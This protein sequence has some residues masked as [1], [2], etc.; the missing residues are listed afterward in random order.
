MRLQALISNLNCKVL[1]AAD[2]DVTGICYDSRKVDKGSPGSGVIFAAMPGEHVDGRAFVKDAVARGASCVLTGAP[3]SG[4]AAPQVVVEDVREALS[5]IS[6]AFY[7]DPSS[8]LKIAGVTGTNGKTTTAYLLES[9]FKEAGFQ[10]G[11]IGTVNYRYGG[12]IREAPHTTPQ[13]PELQKILKEMADSGVTHCA[14]EVSSHAL[15]QK[16]VLGCGFDTAVFTNLTHEHLDYHRT[17]DEYFRCKSLLFKEL[18]KERSGPPAVNIDDPWGARLARGLKEAL[19]FSLKKGASIYPEKYD[20]K[21]GG[22]EASVKTPRGA[23]SISSNLAGEYN[24]HN[25]LGAVGA[26][27]SLGI[28]ID[29]ISSGVAA[30]KRVPGRLEKIESTAPGKRFRAYVDYAHTGDALERALGALRRISTGRIIT[31]FGCGGNRDRL[32]RPEMGEISARLSAFT[33]VTSDNPRDEDPLEIIKEIESGITGVRRWDPEET[34]GFSAQ[35][36]G[37]MAI[38]DRKEAI[39]KAVSIAGDNDTILVA[40]KGHEDCQIVKGTKFHFNDAE[41][42]KEAVAGLRGA[43]TLLGMK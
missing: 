42:I 40:G 30:L 3:V 5:I 35:D 41:E 29:A 23:V 24:L 16:R 31:V 27:L 9:I 34:P 6:S 4:V 17:M 18:L 26:A 13:A 36:K 39:R 25:I 7:G 19:T 10:A 12:H 1:G 14:M 21:E 2:V 15:G 32:K 33:I 37:Y 28:P 43:N 22:I 11:V 38:P 20:L 8:R